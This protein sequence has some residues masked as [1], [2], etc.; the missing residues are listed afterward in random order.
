MRAIKIIG[1]IA[2]LLLAFCFAAWVCLLVLA[3][4]PST[5][6]LRDYCILVAIPFVPALGLGSAGWLLIAKRSS[7]LSGKS[8]SWIACVWIFSVATGLITIPAFV[9]ARQ[10][11]ATNA[12][13]NNLRQ[14]DAAKQQWALENGASTNSRP[15]WNAICPYISRCT[16]GELL[17][18]PNGGVYILGK[19]SEPPK[20]SLGGE[21]HTLY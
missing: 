11:S 14:I 4:P 5:V 20:C 2:S 18:C 16:N 13:T 3:V 8:V 9:R 6:T 10:T 15:N 12:C 7:K 19:V 17:R 1:G 21:G